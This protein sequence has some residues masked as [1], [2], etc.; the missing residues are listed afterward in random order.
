MLSRVRVAQYQVSPKVARAVID[1]NSKI[2]YSVTP[3]GSELLIHIGE[4]KVT[5]NQ[6]DTTNDVPSEPEVTSAT[7]AE[8]EIFTRTC[9][10]TDPVNAEPTPVEITPSSTCKTES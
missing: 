7:T 1:L 10:M 4:S 3:K 9:S 2:P 6:A 8:P 5:E